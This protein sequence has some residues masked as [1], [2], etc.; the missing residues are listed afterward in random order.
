MTF[1]KIIKLFKSYNKKQTLFR[2]LKN[3]FL[4]LK[5]V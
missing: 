4:K 5:N 1:K 2:K 3:N